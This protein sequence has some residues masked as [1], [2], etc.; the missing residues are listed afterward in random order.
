MLDQEWTPRDTAL[1]VA[2]VVVVGLALAWALQVL[3]G[4]GSVSSG[5]A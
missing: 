5:T 1:V 4:V 3:L 2:A